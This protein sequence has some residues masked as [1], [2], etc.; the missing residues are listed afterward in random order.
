MVDEKEQK[1]IMDLDVVMKSNDCSYIVQ[2]YGAIFKEGDCWIGFHR[3]QI[4]LS[5]S[6]TGETFLG[7]EIMSTSL[8]KFYKYLFDFRKIQ[9]KVIPS[10]SRFVCESQKQ[11]IPENILGQITVATVHALNYLK[12]KLKIIHRDVKPSNIL[13]HECGDIKLCDFGISGQLIG[14]FS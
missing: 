5:I 6:F 12:E 10:N 2:F 14:K 13:L 8:D 9:S 4:N 7:M 1:R 3:I 11:R